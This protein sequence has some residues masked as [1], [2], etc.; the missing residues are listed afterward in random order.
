[1]DPKD[2]E[3]NAEDPSENKSRKEK[4]NSQENWNHAEEEKAVSSENVKL[5]QEKPE[6]EKDQKD[7]PNL[8]EDTP[9][10]VF[11]QEPPPDHLEEDVKFR[12]FY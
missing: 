4:E 10:C 12:W 3:E 6:Q 9:D 5:V 2:L 1:V 11:Q 8:L 7:L